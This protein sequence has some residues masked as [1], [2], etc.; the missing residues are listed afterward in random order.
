MACYTWGSHVEA[1]DNDGRTPL[2]YAARRGLLE[3]VQYLVEIGANVNARD[4]ANKTVFDVAPDY[5]RN[6]IRQAIES[7]LRI[8]RHKIAISMALVFT[9][10]AMCP[11]GEKM[12]R[13]QLD[14]FL[15]PPEDMGLPGI[16]EF[17]LVS[18]IT[19]FL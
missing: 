18:L 4:K 19:K 11:N 17:E 10:W 1:K 6:E 5:Y 9:Q 3:I 2:H 12:S 15:H 7:G 16:I 13:D 14:Q 8:R